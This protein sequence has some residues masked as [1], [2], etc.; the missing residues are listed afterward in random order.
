M[1]QYTNAKRKADSVIPQHNCTALPGIGPHLI[2]SDCEL[3]EPTTVD[4]VNAVVEEVVAHDKT[5]LSLK[6][7]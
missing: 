6:V 7:E 4:S 2:L 3:G 1:Y 5:K